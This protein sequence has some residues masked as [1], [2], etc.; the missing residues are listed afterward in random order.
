MA[1]GIAL[2]RNHIGIVIAN[3]RNAQRRLTG[4]LFHERFLMPE[5]Y[6]IT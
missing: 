3:Q 4:R 6:Q 1:S 2:A 5:Y